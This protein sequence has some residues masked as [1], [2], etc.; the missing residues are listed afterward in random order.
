MRLGT[1]E[2]LYKRKWRHRETNWLAPGHIASKGQSWDYISDSLV[3]QSVFLMTMPHYLSTYIT[4]VNQHNNPERE[5]Y[6]PHFINIKSE[7]PLTHSHLA[8][9]QG[10]T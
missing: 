2:I 1:D 8:K 7:T 3:L 9:E 10:L 5:T 6:H 4:S